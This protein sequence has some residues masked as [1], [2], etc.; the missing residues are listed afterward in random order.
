MD[1]SAF[2]VALIIGIAVAAVFLVFRELVTWYIKANE[3]VQ[4]QTKTNELLTEIATYLNPNPAPAA[5]PEQ[6]PSQPNNI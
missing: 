6:E 5:P 2:T 3:L 1:G 4:L